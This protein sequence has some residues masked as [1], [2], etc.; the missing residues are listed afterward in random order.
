LSETM[1]K[2]TLR[3]INSFGV[4]VAASGVCIYNTVQRNN[5]DYQAHPVASIIGSIIPGFLAGFAF[6]WW[7]GWRAKRKQKK[8]TTIT[9]KE[10]ASLLESNIDDQNTRAINDFLRNAS[11]RD[12]QEFIHN[13]HE[14]SGYIQRARTALDIRLAEDSEITSRRIVHL[15]WALLAVSVALLALP[16]LQNLISKKDADTH[17][18]QFQA[19]QNQEVSKTVANARTVP[20]TSKDQNSLPPRV[21][22]VTNVPSVDELLDQYLNSGNKKP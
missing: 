19:D 9:P 16:F 8:L 3:I 13:I 1:K 7:K 20:L 17:S 18:H 12:I 22:G 5:I 10:A 4:A 11:A 2:N 6:Y 15:T 21:S 14:Q